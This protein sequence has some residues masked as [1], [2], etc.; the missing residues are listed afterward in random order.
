MKDDILICSELSRLGRSIF[1]IME[2]LNFCMK[3][4]VKIWTIKYNY[5][6]GEDIQS[7]VL[8]FAFWIV[9]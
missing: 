5:R 8:V 6:L 7:K 1:M 9:C 2:V 3:K 4:E